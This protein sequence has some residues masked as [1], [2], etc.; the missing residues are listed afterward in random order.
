MP[1]YKK[2]IRNKFKF[3]RKLR[4]VHV[5]GYIEIDPV[6]LIKLNN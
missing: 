3:K 6:E 5:V 1:I 4:T 2:L